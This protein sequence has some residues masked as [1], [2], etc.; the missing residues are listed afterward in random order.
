M[1]RAKELVNR[2]LQGSLADALA[3]ELSVFAGLFASEDRREGMSAFVE[4]REPRFT[5]R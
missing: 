3:A 2:S 4:K 5:G 1:S